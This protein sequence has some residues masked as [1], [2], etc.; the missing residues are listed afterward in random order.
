MAAHAHRDADA[1]TTVP[2]GGI[3]KRIPPGSAPIC[4]VCNKKMGEQLR[5]E[6]L[7]TCPRCKTVVLFDATEDK[8]K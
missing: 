6:S 7:M 3:T 4:P 8:P 2:M 5:G 1:M